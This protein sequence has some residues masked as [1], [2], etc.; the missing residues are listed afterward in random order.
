MHGRLWMVLLIF[1]L[2][3]AALSQKIGCTDPEAKNFDHEAIINDGSC[4]YAP[5][6]YRPRVLVQHLPDSVM[7]TSGL[8]LW[9]DSFW[10]HN[11]SDGG[12]ILYRLDPK[13][14]K[15]I[16]KISVGNATNV[17]WEDIDQDDQ[18]IYIGDFGNNLGSRKDLVIY[19][20]PKNQ[21][22][23][24]GNTEVAAFMIH[25]SYGDQTDF[26]VRNRAND[27]DC[28]AM[29]SF[30][31][32]LFIFTKDWVS[33]SSKMY[34]VPKIPGNYLIYPLDE[35]NADGLITGAAIDQES[36]Q[37]I[38]SG[39]KNYV[40]FVW[41][42]DDYWRNDFFGGNKRKIDF[43]KLIGSQTEGITYTG[44]GVFIISS[45]KTPVNDAKLFRFDVKDIK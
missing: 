8:I 15:I 27:Y 9:R 4:V 36:K 26:S 12:N 3:L 28:E 2:P 42:L 20:I 40:P 7:E 31:D 11:D 14:G 32:S 24:Y 43:C 35:F 17:D 1:M 37:L 16:Q 5:K 6:S 29:I 41:L 13:S 22:A 21:I 19:K 23:E 25:F 45:E 44:N 10:T 33:L 34:A 38:L 30:G 18:F 39:Y